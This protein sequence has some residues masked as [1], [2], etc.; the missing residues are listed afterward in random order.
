MS[1]SSRRLNLGSPDV[2][3]NQGRDKNSEDENLLAVFLQY[4]CARI[5]ERCDVIR[6]DKENALLHD[7]PGLLL[8]TRSLKRRQGVGINNTVFARCYRCNEHEL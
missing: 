8:V 7:S 1:N 4:F 2:Q 3:Q 5:N 6:Y